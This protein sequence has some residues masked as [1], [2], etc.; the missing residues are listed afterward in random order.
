[1]RFLFL[2]LTMC[3]ASV[4]A[5]A[6]RSESLFK[7]LGRQI[8][9]MDERMTKNAENN[10]A[11]WRRENSCIRRCYHNQLGIR[12]PSKGVERRRFFRKRNRILNRCRSGCIR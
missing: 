2:V 11:N 12:R 8:K 3:L 4:E 5:R 7:Y 9:N 6:E 10:R 1:M